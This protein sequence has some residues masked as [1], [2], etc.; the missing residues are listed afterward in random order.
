MFNPRG[1]SHGPGRKS[2]LSTIRVTIGVDEAGHRFS[3]SDDWTTSRLPPTRSRR[4]TGVTIFQNE[5]FDDSKFGGDQR[6]QRERAGDPVSVPAKKIVWA[7]E[8][9]IE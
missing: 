6:R 5:G 1:V 8:V 4:W 9:D 2:R 3:V 7:D